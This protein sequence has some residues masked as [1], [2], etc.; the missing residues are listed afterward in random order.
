MLSSCFTFSFFD[1][2]QAV[3]AQANKA[4]TILFINYLLSS[5]IKSKYSTAND[6]TIVKSLPII[7]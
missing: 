3:K 5:H 6:I 7:F 1:D 4:N 2:V